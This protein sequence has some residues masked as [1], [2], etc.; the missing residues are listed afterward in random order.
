MPDLITFTNIYWRE[1]LWLLVALQPFIVIIIKNLV[2]KKNLSDF[3]DKNLHQ[4]LIFPPQYSITRKSLIKHIFS[5]N[6]AYLLAWLCLAISLAGPRFALSKD[7][8]E[9]I[10][11]ANIMLVVDLSRSMKATDVIPSR[12]RRAKI[13]INELLDKAANHRIGIT[14][15]SA[16]PHLYVPLTSDHKAL[17]KYIDIMDQLSFPTLGSNPV[18][19][20]LLAA[21]ELNQY[22]G[23]SS[24]VLITD[25]E[26]LPFITDEKY[27][28]LDRLINN[29]I[30]LYILGI[31]TEEGEAILLENSKWLTF[32]NQAVI[33]RLQSNS[34]E[35]L[36]KKYNGK[37]SVVYDDDYEW[38]TLYTNGIAKYNST[39]DITDKQSVLW[40]ELYYF[41]LLPSI[42]LFIIALTPYQVKLIKITAG[43]IIIFSFYPKNEALALDILSSTESRA[44]TLYNDKDYKN[45][46][47]L[48]KDVTGYNGFFGQAS[49]FYKLGDY[50]KAKLF[51]TRAILNAKTDQQRINALY[52]LANSYFRAGDFKSSIS[53]YKDV[54]NYHPGHTASL[55]NIKISQVLLDNIVL[56]Q[57]EEEKILT[58]FRQGSGPRAANIEAGTEISENTS[59]SIGESTAQPDQL[60]PLPD[61][62]DLSRTTIQKLLATGLNNIKL[63]ETGKQSANELPAQNI[64]SD[65]YQAN[66]QLDILSDSQY[67][68]WK[69]LFEM[70][71][72]FPA[73]VEEPH[74]VPGVKPW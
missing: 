10:L 11:G 61:I 46:S 57:R 23:Q 68:L 6:S 49:S 25:G 33:S 29:K 21:N 64:S 59:V 63:A 39:P 27:S 26:V 44:H 42:V 3:A 35:K 73:P 9:K 50:D 54:L 30:P 43:F 53:T 22:K 45:A 15:F 1:P 31:G 28:H 4:W 67:L 72:G 16:R 74:A 41:F 69:R 13:E 51:F 47:I 55:H 24:I 70:E 17:K 20:I 7:D 38:E 65:I 36:A 37:Y 18:D 14:V 12:I 58:A 34:L 56:R 62:P 52:N 19:A 8:S 66:Q 5:K 71:Q 32:N 60:I 2:N 40:R 48:Y